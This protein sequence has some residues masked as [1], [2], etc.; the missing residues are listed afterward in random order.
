MILLQA[1]DQL[2]SNVIGGSEIMLI[3]LIL[4]VILIVIFA[5][6][7]K[8]QDL[9]MSDNVREKIEYIPDTCPHCKSPN[10]KKMKE[11]EWCGGDTSNV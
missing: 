2:S 5:N 1:T 4:I 8:Q 7:R 11:C 10:H 3:F 6:K 9:P